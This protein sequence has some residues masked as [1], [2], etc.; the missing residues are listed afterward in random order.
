MDRHII[1]FLS[2]KDRKMIDPYF[3][4]LNSQEKYLQILGNLKTL[5]T[6]QSRSKME[7]FPG[8]SAHIAG[9]LRP[10]ID[11]FHDKEM[12]EAVTKKIS[13]LK[14]KG[15]LSKIASLLK[16]GLQ[17]LPFGYARISPAAERKK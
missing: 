6:I 15:D 10:V 2:V 5:A 4:E 9:M 11:R 17:E 7:P 16:A 12:R 8:I 3:V 1:A 14:D 13:S